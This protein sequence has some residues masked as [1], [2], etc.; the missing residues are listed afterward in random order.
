[1]ALRH[2]PSMPCT[3]HSLPLRQWNFHLRSADGCAR[4]GAGCMGPHCACHQV[5]A[6]IPA[7]Q[8]GALLC[9]KNTPAASNPARSRP[10]RRVAAL[11]LQ[12]LWQG[13]LP[14]TIDRHSTGCCCAN[15][16]TATAQL[17]CHLCCCSSSCCTGQ[18]GHVRHGRLLL[19]A[20]RRAAASGACLHQHLDE[21]LRCR[22]ARQQARARKTSWLR[23]MILPHDWT[24]VGE[25][26]VGCGN[27]TTLSGSDFIPLF[28][29]PSCGLG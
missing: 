11:L 27:R 1:M 5:A 26:W 20:G 7:A 22:K 14:C 8:Q 2:T 13:P 19:L 6:C 16:P 18:R 24:L 15:H 21:A 17:C 10:A 25:V 3:T 12:H 9:I 29:V 28:I 23:S 4:C